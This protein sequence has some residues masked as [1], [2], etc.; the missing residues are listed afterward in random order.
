MNRAWLLNLQASLPNSPSMVL[1]DHLGCLRKFESVGEILQEFYTL[2]L[3]YYAKR[4]KYM[5]GLLGSE[6]C[7]LS[8]QARFILEKCDG[9]LKIEN[10]K[11][12][13]MIDELQR[14]GYDSDPVKAW[15]K[16]LA[17]ESTE[18]S[19]DGEES[20]AESQET[21]A[22]SKGPDFDYLLGM[23]M[24]NLTQEK[25]DEICRKRDEKTQELKNL[26]A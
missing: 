15:K 1:F 4:K 22:D 20:E 26:Q 23:P 14:R 5:E 6:A 9:T 25:K 21:V 24:W 10:K 2:R 17:V 3:E 12:K 13:V 18:D 16:S 8:N 19:Q 7:K 11:K